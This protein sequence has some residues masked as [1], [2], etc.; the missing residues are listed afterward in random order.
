MYVFIITQARNGEFAGQTSV[1]LV[2]AL[3]EAGL[4]FVVRWALDDS[5]ENPLAAAVNCLHTL[6]V[7]QQD[8]VSLYAIF[9]CFDQRS[10]FKCQ[11]VH[12]L[13]HVIKI[14]IL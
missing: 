4:L 14:T 9:L 2:P 11:G 3:L 6:L 10:I 7:C 5:A 1:P 12:C 8:E 13:L